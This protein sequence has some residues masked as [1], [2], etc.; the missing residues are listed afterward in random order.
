MR[1]HVQTLYLPAF[2]LKLF[3]TPC[4]LHNISCARLKWISRGYMLCERKLH[5]MHHVHLYVSEDC[6]HFIHSVI[7]I[8]VRTGEM[9]DLWGKIK[10]IFVER[11]QTGR[12][13]D[14]QQRE[15]AQAEGNL[16]R[17]SW[18]HIFVSFYGIRYTHEKCVY[19]G[20]VHY[21]KKMSPPPHP[22]IIR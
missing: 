10:R 18:W 15:G 11:H 1:L 7:P 19:S 8:S 5:C 3:L 13:K 12:V 9:C 2:A 6:K 22:G 21:W 20:V 17:R 16:L 4:I 14:E